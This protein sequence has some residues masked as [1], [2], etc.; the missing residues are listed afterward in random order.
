MVY[1]FVSIIH[2]C[3]FLFNQKLKMK[4]YILLLSLFSLFAI[5]N[6]AYAN[7]P[8]QKPD[9]IA[10][11]YS[12]NE[13]VIQSFKAND[14]VSSEPISASV[15]SA[16]IIKDRNI[17]N[18]KD[19]SAFVPNFFVPEYGSKMTSPAYIRGI[20]SRI[21]SPSVGL[22][23]DGIPYF[24][25]STFDFNLNDVERIEVLRGPQGTIY[26]RNTMGGIIN[27][28][29]KSPFRYQETNLQLGVGSYGNYSL[30][31]SHYHKI[32][33]S[34]GYALSANVEHGDGYFKN[35]F[36]GKKADGITSTAQR[37]RLSW[38]AKHNLY[39][40]LTSAYEYSDQDGYPYGIYNPKSNSIDS[41]NY[42][43]AS[44]FR[45]NMSTTGLNVDYT[46][47]TFRLASQ[48]S[49]QYFDG[50]QGLDQ[51][52]M[53]QDLFYVNFRQAQRMYSQ[54]INIKSIDRDQS[55]YKWLFGVFGFYQNYSTDNNIQ[56]IQ[57][58]YV[59]LQQINSPT[60]GI[61]LF[62]QSV[63][64][65]FLVDGLSATIGVRYDLE[66]IKAYSLFTTLAAGKDPKV[67][68]D[69]ADR[70]TYSQFTPKASLAY[71]FPTG[72]LVYATLTRGYKAGG[73]NNTAQLEEDLS[74]KPEYSWNYE[75]GTK[76]SCFNNLIYTDFS[77][78]YIDWRNQ[79]VAQY[80][81][82]GR[83][84]VQRNAGQSSSK[85]VELTLH[86]NPINNLSFQLNY[87][88]TYA[89]F[90]KYQSNDTTI[91]TGKLLPMVPRNTFSAA[92][93]YSLK[94]GNNSILDKLIFNAQYSG[95]GSLYWREDNIA[96]QK[97]YGSIN[98]KVTAVRG[99]LSVEFWTKNI[100]DTH[101]VSYFFASMGG[102]YAQMGK[103]FTCGM[104][105][106][107][108]F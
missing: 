57:E 92:T 104:N 56:Y 47:H 60:K 38:R 73:F 10:M 71:T 82:N 44:Y 7:N 11:S 4:K 86:V 107:L 3:P 51:D 64:D 101:Y 72:E 68:K 42:N 88:Y 13:V 83:G 39:L 19:V 22:Y 31:G 65:H 105:V 17:T 20:G 74:F 95:L 23:V 58:K 59:S 25:R 100:G 45:R 80:Q 41:I 89:K 85:G 67:T 6:V 14:K 69:Q 84:F 28:Y 27:V 37:I 53:P 94:M 33:D 18:I 78:F 26:G 21:N 29:T 32:G 76:A 43:R 61:A 54:E 52:F 49:F 97:F 98:A 40:H 91:Y 81:P 90:E 66:Q 48:T 5:N 77:L 63:F 12:V 34:F 16:Q 75:I 106:N 15:L 102:N 87:G 1:T 79:Q 2:N 99:N 9:S 62:H 70:A 96:K 108:K 103:P 30:G 36:T 93:N 8:D 24:D 55:K 35:K 46:S 50:H